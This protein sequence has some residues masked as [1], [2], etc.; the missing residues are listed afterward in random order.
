[1]ENMHA[2]RM[3]I[4]RNLGETSPSCFVHLSC[5]VADC[6]CKTLVL[7]RASQG[8]GARHTVHG[9]FASCFHFA[10]ALKKQ[11]FLAFTLFEQRV[12]ERKLSHV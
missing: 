1:M 10:S 2:R 3:S 9:R 12:P 5:Y 6:F 11:I 8:E 4:I 7:P